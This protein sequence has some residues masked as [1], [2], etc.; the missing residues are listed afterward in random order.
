[1]HSSWSTLRWDVLT[2]STDCPLSRCCLSGE[3][4]G[5]SGGEFSLLSTSQLPP[6]GRDIQGFKPQLA[7]IPMLACSPGIAFSLFAL[8][9][10][11]QFSE[12]GRAIIEFNADK[13]TAWLPTSSKLAAQ[14]RESG[15]HS[16]RS[17]ARVELALL[18]GVTTRYLTQMQSCPLGEGPLRAFCKGEH[19]VPSTSTL[20]LL[21]V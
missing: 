14:T 7:P 19:T 5:V 10:V 17:R 16:V 8:D 18:A 3:T 13:Y 12:G 21:E 15:T 2:G 4:G 1:M 6:G 9:V 11:L 20:S